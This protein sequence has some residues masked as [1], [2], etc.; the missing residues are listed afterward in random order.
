MT[1]NELPFTDETEWAILVI[2]DGSLRYI[3]TQLLSCNFVSGK[4]QLLT[5]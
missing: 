5:A 4:K 1:G 3:K 2:I